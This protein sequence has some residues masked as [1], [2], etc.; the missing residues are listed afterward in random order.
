MAVHHEQDFVD[1]VQFCHQLG[2]L[3]GCERLAGAGGVPD[4]TVLV[5]VLHAIQDLLYGI[6]LVRAQD[7][8]AFVAFVEDDVLAEHLAQGAFVKE[9]S[10]ELAKVVYRLIVDERPVKSEFVAAVG[11]V[12]EIAGIDAVGDD[13]DLDVIEQAAEGGLLVALH[14]IV[15]LLEFYAAF[16]ELNLYQRKAVDKD[17][18]VVAAGLA[19]LNS[20]L[21]GYLEFILAP[22]VLVEEFH[23]DA[24]LAI[25]GFHWKEVTEFLGLLEEGAAF[26]VD[27]DFLE[28]FVRERGA[29]DFCQG[30]GIMF[31][32]LLLEVAV[33][34][35]FFFDLDILI[36]HVLQSRNQPVFK[37]LFALCCHLA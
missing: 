22:V 36:A 11:I 19:A 16:L 20:N 21:V 32:K 25:L 35:G 27:A 29:A 34:V 30:L 1:A 14:L 18:D 31:F 5:C 10:C 15:G 7:H 24:V 9:V 3:E 37:S 33:E 23:P 17:G 26:Q 28:L 13:K 2:R 6:V 4:V 12:G 8:Q